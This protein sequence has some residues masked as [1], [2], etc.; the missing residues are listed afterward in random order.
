MHV[1]TAKPQVCC[2]KTFK[3]FLFV[4]I[5]CKCLTHVFFNTPKC[6][7]L[8]KFWFIKFLQTCI[9]WPVLWMR[10]EVDFICRLFLFKTLNMLLNHH[11][12]R[13]WLFVYSRKYSF[14]LFCWTLENDKPFFFNSNKLF[15]W[16]FEDLGADSGNYNNKKNCITHQF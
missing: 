1:Y 9:F 2:I 4:V 11:H 16:S 13:K 12:Q 15:W 14:F 10:P 8:S 5:S 3:R 7:D 6:E